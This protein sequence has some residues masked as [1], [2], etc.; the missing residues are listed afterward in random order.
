MQQPQ[1][2]EG[3]THFQR[4]DPAKVDVVLGSHKSKRVPPK[5]PAS[6][7]GWVAG[8][9]L[10]GLC[11]YITA[12]HMRQP[13]VSTPVAPDVA[14]IQPV[15]VPNEQPAPVQ[16]AA[17][18]DL[19]SV[20]T[21]PRTAPPPVPAKPQPVP[22]QGMVSARY[23]AQ[24]KAEQGRPVT[25]VGKVYQIATVEIREWKGRNRYRAQ[26]R[27]VDNEID[28][29]SVCANFPGDSIEH[30]ECRRAAVVYF[31]ESCQDWS[32]RAD[33][34]SD[35]QTGAA[36]QRYCLANKTFTADD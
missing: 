35:P 13:S 15:E 23:M 24:Y 25:Q 14:R 31:K 27:I 30:R 18:P 3:V 26:W 10:L 33:H 36:Q 22:S 1:D 11:A 17:V 4:L 5:P 32:K 6:R 21:A 7:A 9:A 29:A 8:A 2:D 34:E 19:I 16:A 28:N 12:A 20:E